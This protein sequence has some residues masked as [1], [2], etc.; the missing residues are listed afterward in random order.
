MFKCIKMEI[1]A[2]SDLVRFF[3]VEMCFFFGGKV[4]N[5]F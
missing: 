5:S 2:G 4:Y 3:E 1:S